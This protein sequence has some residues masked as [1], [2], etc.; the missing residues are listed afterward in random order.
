M[1]RLLLGVVA[2]LLAIQNVYAMSI[3]LKPGQTDC[4]YE[5]LEK[6][7]RIIVSFQVRTEKN[8]EKMQHQ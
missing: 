4:Y 2:L 5:V 1:N 8:F 6:G 3:L 7:E